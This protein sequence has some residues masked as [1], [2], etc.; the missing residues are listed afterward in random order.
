METDERERVAPGPREASESGDA[1]E[2][3]GAAEGE[4][5]APERVF[6]DA[7]RVARGILWDVFCQATRWDG[8]YDFNA[9]PNAAPERNVFDTHCHLDKI[10]DPQWLRGTDLPFEDF[11]KTH[12]KY[13]EKFEG[14]ITIFMDLAPLRSSFKFAKARVCNIFDLLLNFVFTHYRFSELHYYYLFLV[15]VN[16]LSKAKSVVIIL[17]NPLCIFEFIIFFKV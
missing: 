5:E 17:E 14:C 7:E 16:P 13:Y 4:G 10:L 12:E 8:A 2:S 11:R 1:V 6:T 3:K 9:D 15:Y